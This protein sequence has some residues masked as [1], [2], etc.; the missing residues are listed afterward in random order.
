VICI[1]LRQATAG[2]DNLN[3]KARK[4]LEDIQNQCTG[5]QACSPY[6]PLLNK[7]E[8]L[9]PDE[10][11]RQIVG[12]QIN[13]KARYFI[14]RCD[15][16]GSCVCSC[17]T[18]VDIPGMVT[19]ARAVLA[20]GALGSLEPYRPIWVD[21]DWNI[22]TTYR[23]TYHIDYSD[24]IKGKCDT[25]FFPGCALAS[26]SPELTRASFNW[27]AGRNRET[28]LLLICCGLP[29]IQMGA[30]ERA[31]KY[32]SALQH[33]VTESG[34]QR[35]VTTCPQ[36]HCYLQAD[37]ALAG[38]EVTSIYQLMADAGVRAPASHHDKITIHDSCPERQVK[39]GAYIRRIL[40]K[41]EIVEMEHS[42]GETICCGAGGLTG[43]VDPAV[44]TQRAET[45]MEEF[46]NVGATLCVT[47]C[48]TCALTLSAVARGKV[49]HILELVFKLPLDYVEI[50]RRIEA[51]WQGEQG[52]Y[53]LKRLETSSPQSL[54]HNYGGKANG[55]H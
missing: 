47:Y 50:R 35:I 17:P 23:D 48:M 10:I 13:E 40:S 28:G 16:C 5:C 8:G 12:G 22:F 26:Y 46:R 33:I 1:R 20:E 31:E 36:C 15:L 49:R 38:V 54:K 37:K 34:A 4:I 45:R 25:L 14:Q 7:L 42:G 9:T 44:C 18:S 21:Y 2:I 3:A 55:Y 11:A 29:L 19:A 32:M 24:L 43:I 39:Q 27:L 30:A 52:K 41:Y 51:M 53:N 6:C